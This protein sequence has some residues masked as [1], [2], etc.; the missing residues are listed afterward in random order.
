MNDS[1][2]KNSPNQNQKKLHDVYLKQAKYKLKKSHGQDFLNLPCSHYKLHQTNRFITTE[3][4]QSS[5]AIE[6]DFHRMT[7]TVMKASFRKLKPKVIHYK[8]SFKWRVTVSG[9]LMFVESYDN[10]DVTNTITLLLSRHKAISHY[11]F[12]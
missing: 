12:R 10:C 6:T 7:A 3:A 2:F 11:D 5:C 9:E 1:W 8:N 4:T